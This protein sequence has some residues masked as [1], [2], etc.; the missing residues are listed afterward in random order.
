MEN[1]VFGIMPFM[2]VDY[3][4]VSNVLYTFL[5]STYT[6]MILLLYTFEVSANATIGKK[7]EKP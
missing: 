7:Q 5:A 3:I 1:A 4:Y 2:P 6:I